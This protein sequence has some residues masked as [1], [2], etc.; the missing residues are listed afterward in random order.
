MKAVECGEKDGHTELG[1]ENMQKLIYLG[2]SLV[3]Q[4]RRKSY[5]FDVGEIIG[6]TQLYV[7]GHL[8]E[9]LF[10]VTDIW[11]NLCLCFLGRN[12]MNCI[13]RNRTCF[14]QPGAWPCKD[15]SGITR[16]VLAFLQPQEGDRSWD[17]AWREFAQGQYLSP[18]WEGGSL[19]LEENVLRLCWSLRGHGGC[20]SSLPL[21]W[22]P[23]VEIN[24]VLM[25]LFAVLSCQF[26]PSKEGRP[27]GKKQVDTK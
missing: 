20:L 23:R 7:K 15:D 16:T 6:L 12:R 8:R 25:S 27:E 9:V 18:L 14:G 10:V 13:S 4:F 3:G 21:A 22:S 19:L 5:I 11:E 2:E 26:S 17:R 1:I 24:Q